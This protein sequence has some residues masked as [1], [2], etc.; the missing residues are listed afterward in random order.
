MCTYIH[1][2]SERTSDFWTCRAASY[3]YH[4]VHNLIGRGA[5]AF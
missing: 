2:E 1:I 4:R 5:R 3:E